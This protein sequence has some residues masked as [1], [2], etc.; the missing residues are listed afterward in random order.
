MPKSSSHRTRSALA[1]AS[2]SADAEEI[3]EVQGHPAA[4]S[5]SALAYAIS[6]ESITNPAA[7]PTS[8]LERRAT[9]LDRSDP[10]IF[11]PLQRVRFAFRE[12][13]AE[14]IGTMVMIMFGDGVVAQYKLSNKEAGTYT[15]IAFS[16]A[17]AV[18]LGY[19]CSAGISGAHLNPGVTLSSAIY[20]T[21]P[22]KKVPGYI[23]AQGL[24]GYVGA[25]L[26]YATYIQSINDF[27]GGNGV[28]SVYGD[29]ASAGIFCTFPAPFLN[30]KGQVASELVASALLQFGIFSMTDPHNAALG[31][32]FPF[33]L[34][35]LIYGLGTSFGYQT[36][37]AINFA[38]DFTPRLAALTVGYG[39]DMFTAYHHYFWVPMIIPVIG[40]LLG[41]F[42]YDFFIYQGLDSPLNQPDLGYKKTIEEVRGFRMHH[43]RPDFDVE[44]AHAS[45]S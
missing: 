45:S 25:L 8:G 7:A 1:S 26:V 2:T 17:T 23:F 40:C 16:W 13:L 21:F 20:R 39:T 37:Y 42:I 18:F 38:R 41:G 11:T 10:L 44:Q 19:A 35:I 12:Y 9:N 4:A 29:T 33:G 24:G 22:W 30:T 14:F 27:E 32:F 31:S 43:M 15:T 6:H 5:A 3:E 34:W 28:R 36:G